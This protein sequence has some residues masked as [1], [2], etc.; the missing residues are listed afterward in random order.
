MPGDFVRVRANHD[1]A[2]RAGRDGLV[3]AVD[4]PDVVM[5]FRLDRS[6]RYSG[7]LSA[8]VE[9]WEISELDL[10]TVDRATAYSEGVEQ[11]YRVGDVLAFH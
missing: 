3:L 9:Q 11:R 1:D 7:V 4:G 8:G 2:T 5:V 6:G 10:A